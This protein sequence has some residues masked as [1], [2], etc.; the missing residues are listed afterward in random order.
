M[1]ISKLDAAMHQL[2]AALRLFFEGDYLSSLTLAGAAEGILSNLCERQG[3]PTA[4]DRIADFHM[5]D[6]DPTL[7][8][9]DRRKVVFTVLNRGR[10][11]A[12]HANVADEN[13][14]DVGQIYPLQ[15]L[16]RAIPMARELGVSPSSEMAQL[17]TWIDKH[18]E[19]FE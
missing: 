9:K 7:S 13:T 8:T 18:P 17:D 11:Q 14:V 5:K 2:N 10:N 16:M 15:M 19:A 3:L 4:A 6:T 12:K 1:E